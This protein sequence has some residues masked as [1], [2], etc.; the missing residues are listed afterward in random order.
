M[1]RRAGKGEVSD[2]FYQI[3]SDCTH[4]V[5][6]T[7]FKIKVGK[8]L[9]VR[10]WH[11]AFTREGRLDIASVLNRIQKG[12]VHPTIRGEVWEFLLG[13]FDPGSTFDEREQIREKRRVEYSN[14]YALPRIESIILEA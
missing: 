8:T 14:A 4:K 13:C 1:L 9:S 10:K 3:R 12:G 2:G 7:K 5:P 6:E 11:A